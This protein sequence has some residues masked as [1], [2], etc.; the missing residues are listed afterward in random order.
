MQIKN[1]K[2]FIIISLVALFIC[3]SNLNADE[4]DITAKEI[5]I[6]KDNETIIG[7]GSVEAIDT[8][9]KKI[10]ADKITY[11]KSKEFLLAEGNVKI[12]DNEGNILKTNKATYDKINGKIITYNN[13]QLYLSE[14]YQLNG[15]NIYYDMNEKILNSSQKSIFLDS[16]KNIIETE[17]FHYNL[18]NNLFSSLGK[19]K[20]LDNNKN[21]YFFK[22]IY[23]DT[24]KKEMIGSDVSVVLDEKNFGLTEES[25]P[26]FVAN[27]IFISKDKSDLSKGIFTVC[28]KRDGKCPPWSLKARKIR[29]DKAKKT[30]FYE[31]ATLKVYD[32]PIFYFP[33][34]F[35]PDPTVKRQSGFLMPTLT[36]STTVGTGLTTPY[37][38]AI[39]NDKDLTFTPK[40]YNQENLLFLN[41][42][43]QAFNNAFLIL[44]TSYTQGYKETTSKKNEGSRSHFFGELDI[45]L[46]DEKPYQSNLFLKVQKATNDTYFKVHSIKTALVN[47]DDTTLKNEI[48]YNFSGDNTYFDIRANIYED[49]SKTTNSRYEYFLP[50]I[51]YGK[52]FFTEKF[53][54]LNFES[55]AFYNNYEVNKHKTFF[56]NDLIWNPP[57]SISKIGFVNSIEGMLRNTNY[58]TKKTGEYK[59]DGTINELNGVIA[60]KSSIPMKKD[61]INFSNFFS[62]N[63]MIRFA[64]G[65][66]RNINDKDAP[67]NYTNLYSLNKTSE[68]EDGLS[69]IL[70][71]DFKVN[72]K[73]SQDQT[74]EKLTFSVGQV[75]NYEKNSDIP[76][77]SSLD[78]KMSDVVGE[79]NYNFSSIGSL[80]YKFSLDHNFN[81]LNYNEISTD[82]NF[83]KIQFNLDYLEELNHVGTDHYANA[84][85]DLNFNDSNKLSFSTKKNFKTDSTEFYNLSY[86]YSIDCLKAGLVYRRE[87]Y[88]DD[89]LEPNNSLMFTISFVPFGSAI[90]PAINP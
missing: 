87:F 11:K 59:D 45:N 7:E 70:G 4:F 80:G 54:T 72:Q 31:H 5:L 33:R 27:N 42:Y 78:Q 32:I 35:H 75:F 49:L 28:K 16:D 84:G 68:I 10:I 52:T 65:H 85:L 82:L 58:E 83:G 30:I 17:M 6:D 86:Q 56:T 40:F 63:L 8:E 19:I 57:S 61:G 38:W 2:K 69:A 73:I 29:H 60:Y 21:K 71:F 14:G 15:K 26:R 48:K 46:A 51:I 23:V 22:E 20:I 77:Q 9:G 1:K 74:K 55:N 47:T 64:P 81:E 90:T 76:S 89:D 50:N 3:I 18:N 39:S 66:M 37:Y 41:E 13:T 88:Q 12:I 79:V 62:P 67:L 53:G 34:F 25:D 24:K 43:R 44:D 36:N